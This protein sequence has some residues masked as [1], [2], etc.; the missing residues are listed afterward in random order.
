[1]TAKSDERGVEVVE[2]GASGDER[3]V[4]AVEDPE[5]VPV[6]VSNDV[7]SA[8][9]DSS[10]SDAAVEVDSKGHGDD[11]EGAESEGSSVPGADAAIAAH[12]E[13][14]ADEEDQG[15]SHSD[16]GVYDVDSAPQTDSDSD[17]DGSVASQVCLMARGLHH[18][19]L[20]AECCFLQ[21]A[22]EADRGAVA[23]ADEL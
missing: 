16:D 3:D 9:A 13:S 2:N 1:M 4:Q 7:G 11:A 18:C 12:S 10:D 6:R 17:S 5:V 22:D 21:G 14:G 19:L 20:C 23:D 8:H 15:S